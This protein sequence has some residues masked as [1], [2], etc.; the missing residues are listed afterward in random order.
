[1]VVAAV[2]N[3]Y[4][5]DLLLVSAHVLRDRGEK[6]TFEGLAVVTFGEKNKQFLR[7][8][9]LILL[10]GFLCGNMVAMGPVRTNY[11]LIICYV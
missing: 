11:L 4:T 3:A 9:L 1:M 5:S 10:F 7:Y 6:I 8:N 2:F